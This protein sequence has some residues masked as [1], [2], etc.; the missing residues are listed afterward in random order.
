[1]LVGPKGAGKTTIGESLARKLGI[2][3]LRVEPIYLACMQA[4]PDLSPSDL[5][6]IGFGAILDAVEE[7]ANNS[8]VICLETTGAAGYFPEFLG[9]LQASYHLRLVRIVASAEE[10]LARVRKRDQANHIPVSDERV[11][12]INRVAATVSLPWDME[13]DNS[14][15]G[16][17]DSSVAEVAELIRMRSESH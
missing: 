17:L 12:E 4:N 7:H 2:T 6:P 9:R 3:F 8:P 5:E 15:E 16:S 11:L 1:M 10:C 13:V 14:E